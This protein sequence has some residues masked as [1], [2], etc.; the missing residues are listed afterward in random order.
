M[1]NLGENLFKNFSFM[2]AIYRIIGIGFLVALLALIRFYEKSLFYDPLIEF[3]RA[4]YLHGV[5]PQFETGKFLLHVF[6]RFWVNSALSLA[7]LYVAFLDKNILK[8]SS[9][10]YMILF[11]AS[12]AAFAFLIFNIEEQHFMALFYVRRF[13]IHPLFVIILLPAFYYYRL[14]IRNNNKFDSLSPKT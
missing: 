1:D 4:E 6:Y 2:K 11:I 3:Y 9:F 12:F 10:L 13:L 7:I 14:K 8:F 5:I